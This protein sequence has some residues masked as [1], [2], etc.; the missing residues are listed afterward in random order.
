[1]DNIDTVMHHVFSGPDHAQ[2]LQ[3]WLRMITNYWEAIRILRKRSE[4]TEHD[5]Q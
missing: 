4:Y 5:I 3:I 2:R 1:M